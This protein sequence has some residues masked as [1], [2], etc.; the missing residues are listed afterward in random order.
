MVLISFAGS[1]EGGRSIPLE[2]K[3]R[4]GYLK[5]VYIMEFIS[6][7]LLLFGIH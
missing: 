5:K 2:E 6:L 4:R 7:P 3:S 1:L